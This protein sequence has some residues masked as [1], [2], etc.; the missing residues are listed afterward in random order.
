[1]TGDGQFIVGL[2]ALELVVWSAQHACTKS[3]AGRKPNQTCL[4][5]HETA[6]V[7]TGDR[8]GVPAE[9]ATVTFGGEYRPAF[10]SAFTALLQSSTN[11]VPAFRFHLP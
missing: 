4:A 10:F 7:F 9:I 3:V 1:M 8:K 11:P 2:T 6:G 5:V